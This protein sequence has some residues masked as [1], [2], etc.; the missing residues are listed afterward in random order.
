M[1]IL[2]KWSVLDAACTVLML[3]LACFLPLEEVIVDIDETLERHC[4]KMTAQRVIYE[5]HTIRC[6]SSARDSVRNRVHSLLKV[7]T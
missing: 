5:P 3:L 1:L 4:G 7:V 2:V 6:I